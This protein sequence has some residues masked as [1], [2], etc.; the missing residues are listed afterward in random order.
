MAF[1]RREFFEHFIG[2]AVIVA[3]TPIACD[4]MVKGANRTNEIRQGLGRATPQPIYR[5]PEPSAARVV[6]PQ[7]NPPETAEQRAERMTMLSRSLFEHLGIGES[8]DL[9]RDSNGLTFDER[10]TQRETRVY[11]KMLASRQVLRTDRPLRTFDFPATDA[12]ELSEFAID[13]DS[14]F[15]VDAEV[16]VFHASETMDFFAARWHSIEKRWLF[17]HLRTQRS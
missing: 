12:Q 2:T 6:A 17:T 1:S 7:A 8:N 14:E 13:R 10:M 3:A 5:L 4:Q 15:P 9:K 16:R 11:P